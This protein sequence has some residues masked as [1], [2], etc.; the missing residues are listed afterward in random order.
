MIVSLG[1]EPSDNKR[2]EVYCDSQ[3]CEAREVIVLVRRGDGAN[4]RADVR[5]LAALDAQPA[6]K[7]GRAS[8]TPG[9]ISY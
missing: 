7:P 3:S 2:V 1:D 8:K 4:M 5:A 6:G 9:S